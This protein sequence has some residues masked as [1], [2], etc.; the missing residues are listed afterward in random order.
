M[1]IPQT[2]NQFKDYCLRKLGAPVIEINLDEDQVEDRVDDALQFFQDYHFDGVEKIFMKHKLTA[3]DK[4]RGWIHVPDSVIFVTGI[5]HYNHSGS[6]VNQL[7][8]MYQIELTAM[9]MLF[10]F[11]S[12]S[13]FSYVDY[14]IMRQH[15]RT[16]EL[17]F[18]GTPQFRFHRHLDKLY[19]DINWGKVTV[20][21]YIILEA[22][23]TLSPD[24]FTAAGTANVSSTSTTVSGT[25]SLFDQNFIPG[26]NIYVNNE[27]RRIVSIESPTS[28][29]VDS[30]FSSTISNQTITMIGNSNVWNDR[31][32]KQYATAK[33]KEQ[34]GNNLKKFNG[35]QLPGGISLNGQQI[36]EEAREEIKQLEEEMQVL[37]V[38]PPEILVG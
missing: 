16:L 23:R 17:M 34:W 32:L 14:D 37:N 25:N 4:S 21:D 3:L 26:D 11:T 38:L 13:T 6:S 29:T 1:A 15:L 35:V 24:V 10:N 20:G 8:S 22:Y 12:Y 31:F 2:R 27:Q 36:Y 5:L 9:E 7:G 28:M 19:L 30:A 33:I 18:T